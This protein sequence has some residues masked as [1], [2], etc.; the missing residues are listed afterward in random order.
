MFYSDIINNPKNI[1]QLHLPS[2]TTAEVHPIA[3]DGFPASQQ[4]RMPPI[5]RFNYLRIKPKTNIQAQLFTPGNQIDF[6]VATPYTEKLLLEFNLSVATAA[7]TANLEFCIDR[8][9][10]ISNGIILST[11]RGIN[12]W[13][14]WLFKSY[15]QTV[16][17]VSVNNKSTSLVPQSIAVGNNYIFYVHLWSFVD[18]IQPKLNAIKSNLTFRVYFTDAGIIAGS[19]ANITVNSCDI[20]AQTQ[21]L[22]GMLESLETQRKL[23]R[24]IRYRFLNPI[25]ACSETRALLPSSEYSF[26]LNSTNGL[27]SFIVFHLTTIGGNPDAFAQLNSYEFLDENNTIVGIQMPRQLQVYCSES[28]VGYASYLFPNCYVIPFGFVGMSLEGCECGFYKMTTKEQI[29]IYTDAAF[30][31][32]NYLFEAYTYEYNVLSLC[33]GSAN[34]MK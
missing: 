20:I 2:N 26:R 16:R 7:V 4:T 31:G 25:R 19:A 32:G 15:D 23:N 21:Q 28:F 10:I 29:K 1:N 30:V 33:N 34:I 17:E 18:Y 22:S 8:L 3:S 14:A 12:L 11:L 5:N 27:T 6:E 13:H 9:E 24:D